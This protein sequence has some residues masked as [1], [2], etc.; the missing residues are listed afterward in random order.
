MAPVTPP[1]GLFPPPPTLAFVIDPKFQTAVAAALSEFLAARH[2][3]IPFSFC[4]IDL[5]SGK[6]TGTL[7]CGAHKPDEEDFIA[8]AAKVAAMYAAFALR[9]MV[10]RFSFAA[11]LAAGA[12]TLVQLGGG[13]AAAK[14]PSLFQALRDLVDPAIDAGADPLLQTAVRREQRIPHYEQVL[15]EG[16][17]S[18]PDFRGDF[19]GSMKQMIVP[20]D[21][22]AAGRC[23]RG[24]GYG[25][26]NGAL[27]A[28]G[29]FNAKTRIGVWLAGDFVGHWPYAR[30][31]SANDKGVAQAGSALTMAQLMALIVNRGVLD[32]NACDD[33]RK[34]L[35]AAAQGPDQPWL[36]RGD[37]DDKLRLPLNKVTHAKLGLG[38]LKSGALV[39]SEIFRLEGLFDATRSY[40]IAF[41]NASGEALN[42]VAF[43]VRRSIQLYEA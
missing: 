13:K 34:L 15:V 8:S 2:T 37:V 22:V 32:A 29:L 20:S 26:L 18:V 40:T 42:D 7:K 36:T 4:I 41:Q 43:M 23:I 10:W 19:L 28:A 6:A 38:P 39:L 11:K 12:V 14:P 1:I 25:Y 5:D 24:V 35:A 31:N 16:G 17:P 30:I 27:A 3:Q 33:M 9:D 21:N